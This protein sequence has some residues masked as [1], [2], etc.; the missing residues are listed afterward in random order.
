[1][2]TKASASSERGKLLSK[3]RDAARRDARGREKTVLSVLRAG[4]V[5]LVPSS[6][7]QV[8]SAHLI[9]LLV[10]PITRWILRT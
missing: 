1:M 10:F 6:V 4:R 5:L 9:I 7:V 2:D 8:L 3:L